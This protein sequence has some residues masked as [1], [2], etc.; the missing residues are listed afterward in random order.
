[1]IPMKTTYKKKKWSQK[2]YE[3]RKNAYKKCQIDFVISIDDFYFGK[4][5]QKPNFNI[6]FSSIFANC[7]ESF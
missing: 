4:L 2:L 5:E 7:Q 3:L 6:T 1:M